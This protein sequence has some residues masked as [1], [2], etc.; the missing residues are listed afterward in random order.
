MRARALALA[1]G[2]RAAIETMRGPEE[3]D[4]LPDTAGPGL[5]SPEPAGPAGDDATEVLPVAGAAS[6]L[7]A[8]DTLEETAR[9]LLDAVT[10]FAGSSMPQ[11]RALAAD[12]LA[13][14][15]PRL[16]DP[17]V[18]L[19]ARRIAGMEAPP[20]A[21]MSLLLDH[22]NPRAAELVVERAAVV[23][24]HDL[25][26][27]IAHGSEA[28]MLTI[29]RRRQVSGLVAERLAE[30]RLGPVLLALA[31]NP[32]AT[33]SPETFGLLCDA[34]ASLPALQAP[35]ATRAD[36]PPAYAFELFWHV[37]PDLRRHL[38]TRF[39]VDTQ[40][41]GKIVRSI[42]KAGLVSRGAIDAVEVESFVE[43]LA[44]GQIGFAVQALSGLLA[45][46]PATAERI[47]VDR[48]GEALAAALKALGMTRAAAAK[49][50]DLL[51]QAEHA[52][53]RSD[54][55]TQELYYVFDSLSMNKACVLLT[56]WDWATRRRK[57]I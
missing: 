5:A 55:N 51:V 49:T 34:A 12:A 32:G 25:R 54:R 44:A 53:L 56:Y 18:E 26:R 52:P 21:L 47:V 40:A 1:A 45:V 35:L 42:E 41:V 3:A 48:S 50:I 39:L 7:V 13:L 20:A 43:L 36:L 4:D 31:R 30:T 9:T 29:A 37:P 57:S 11:E 46:D 27:L 15:L 28:A 8:N 33:L 10:I 6:S 2:S 19:I 14:L 22:P 17:T 23:G 38:L 24:E 16:S